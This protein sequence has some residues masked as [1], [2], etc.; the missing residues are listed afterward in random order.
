MLWRAWRWIAR[1]LISSSNRY[2]R[3]PLPGTGA[4]QLAAG[5]EFGCALLSDGS[6]K[7]WGGNSNGEL[8]DATTTDRATPV[9]VFGLSGVTAITVGFDHTCA[10]RSDGTVKCWGA[11]ADGQLGNGS[12][13]TDS[14]IPVATSPLVPSVAWNSSAI[15]V[16]TIDPLS[17]LAT[18]VAFREY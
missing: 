9:Q 8:G 5:G 18:A 17:G 2:W 14:N 16:A 4:S 11:D 15:S 12:S 6:V 7:C 10:T 1:L 13:T 3:Q